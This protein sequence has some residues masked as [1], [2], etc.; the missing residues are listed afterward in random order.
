MTFNFII[1]SFLSFLNNIQASFGEL[2]FNAD[3]KHSKRNAGIISDGNHG[4]T[5]VVCKSRMTKAEGGSEMEAS[6]VAVLLLIPEKIYM[7]EMFTRHAS[8]HETKEKVSDTI[9]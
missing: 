5:R 6:N 1:L 8:K 4:Q 9:F 3:Y 2:S 7:E